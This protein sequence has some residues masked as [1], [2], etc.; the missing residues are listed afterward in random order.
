MVRGEIRPGEPLAGHTTLRIGGPA[1]LYV[2]PAGEEDVA[3]AV[4]AARLLGM[5]LTVLGRGSNILVPDEGVR[6]MVLDPV[7]ATTWLRFQGS[8]VEVG[9]GYPLPGLVRAAV[10]RGLGGLEDLGGIPGSVGG[11]LCM[12]AGA[13]GQTIGDVTVWVDAVGTGG[14]RYRLFAEQLGF[15]Y[16]YSRLLEGDGVVLAAGLE[17]RPAAREA[18]QA[19]LRAGEER[20]R[21]TQP[22]HLPNAGSVFKNPPGDHAGRLLDAAGC[23][24]LRVGGAQISPRHANFIVNLG[25]ATAA[26][27]LALMAEAYRRVR[28]AFGVRLEP[29]IRLLGAPPGTLSRLLEGVEPDRGDA[30]R[31]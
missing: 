2:L 14:E 23:K 29:E 11:A 24:G 8:R 21:R 26:D 27:V 31:Q 13:G 10:E 20:R 3:A 1:D 12:N 6:G 28:D 5:P 4:R 7:A 15:G 22:L 9:A 18:L 19:R 17:L 25:N 30:A 16:R